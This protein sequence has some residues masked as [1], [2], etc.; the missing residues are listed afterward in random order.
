MHTGASRSNTDGAGKV[1]HRGG[2]EPPTPRFVVWCSIQ[3]SY[4]CVFAKILSSRLNLPMTGLGAAGRVVC[5]G[6]GAYLLR[7]D[8]D[9]KN[10]FELF[11]KEL[12]HSSESRRTP[13]DLAVN[14]IALPAHGLRSGTSKQKHVPVR[15][16]SSRTDPPCALSNSATI[17]S[18]RP[19]PPFFEPL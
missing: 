12:S 11:F 19:T 15:L 13:R 1:A 2:F 6:Q 4:R 18:P 5:P 3:L 14:K 9:C 17:A 8:G 16:S 10:L 7:S